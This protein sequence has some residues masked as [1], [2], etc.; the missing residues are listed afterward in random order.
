MITAFARPPSSSP[1]ARHSSF[2]RSRF[3]STRI[4][5]SLA[6]RVTPHKVHLEKPFLRVNEPRRACDVETI[7]TA[8][9][10]NAQIVTLDRHRSGQPGKIAGAVELR[11]A[12]PQ[13]APQPQTAADGDDDNRP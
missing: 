2:K 1:R 4:P 11:Q 8:D 7:H 3:S 10:G 13:P 6:R 9:R 12:R 5:V